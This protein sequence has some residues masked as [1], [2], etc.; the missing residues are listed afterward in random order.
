[1]KKLICIAA[2]LIFGCYPIGDPVQTRALLVVN[3]ADTLPM[4]ITWIDRR[5]ITAIHVASDLRRSATNPA[6]WLFDPSIDI[7]D[8]PALK[9]R[10]MAWA[11]SSIAVMKELNAQGMVVWNIDGARFGSFLGCP[12]QAIEINPEIGGYADEFFAR[13]RAQRFKVGVC[14]RPGEFDK[15]TGKLIPAADPYA[16][17]L[18]KAAFARTRWKC[19]LFYVDSNVLLAPGTDQVVSIL[20]SAIFA[21]LHRALPDCLFL[22]EHEKVWGNGSVDIGYYQGTAPYQEL[23]G[24]DT[25]TP[26]IARAAVPGAFSVLNISDGDVAGNLAAL[27]AAVAKGDIL[28]M[29]GWWRN[30]VEVD[31]IK[32]AY[33]GIR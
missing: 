25:G 26:A 10:F 9:A 23:R 8:A 14:I 32:S 27:Q 18:R 1:M 29:N 30:G 15:S 2:L 21:R 3:P 6:G 5:P 28:M 16:S 7:N 20:P 33:T 19:T 31:A 22:P 11:D 13:F 12:D 4:S 24:G 17:L